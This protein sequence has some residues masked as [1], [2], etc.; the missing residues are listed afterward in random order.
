MKANLICSDNVKSILIELLSGRNISIDGQADICIIESGYS[1]PDN[2]LCILFQPDNIFALIELLNKLAKVNDDSNKI[3]G[4][5]NDERFNVISFDQIYYFEGR[6]N[7]TY[8]ITQDGEYK[9]KEKLYELEA[10]LPQDKFIRVG[11]SF[12]AN[13]ANVKEIIP[14][15]GRRL[16]LR[17]SDNRREIEVSKNYTKSFKEFLGL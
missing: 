13:I 8:C 2:K 10:R 17:F 6:G 4:R 7:Y 11:K 1:L 14:W 5:F 15:F 16:V 9:V 12:I 3:I